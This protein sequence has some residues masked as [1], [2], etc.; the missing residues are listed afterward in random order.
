M[1]KAVEQIMPRALETLK[2]SGCPDTDRL[3]LAYYDLSD[4]VF[5]LLFTDPK[6]LLPWEDYSLEITDTGHVLRLSTAPWQRYEDWNE[7]EQ[8]VTAEWTDEHAT[9]VA[10]FLKRVN[11]DLEYDTLVPTSEYA[12][13]DTLYLELE[14]GPAALFLT[15]RLTPEWQIEYYT[16]IGN[17]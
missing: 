5:T 17:G 3:E 10:E 14:G 13:G 2:A 11:P 12:F 7:H 6:A 9:R 8:P 1:Q 4:G 16:C 15:V